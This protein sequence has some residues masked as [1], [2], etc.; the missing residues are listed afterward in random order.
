M[1]DW[2]NRDDDDGEAAVARPQFGMFLRIDV[3]GRSCAHVYIFMFMLIR[4]SALR[5]RLLPAA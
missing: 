2:L 5:L 1:I 3:Y 4:N